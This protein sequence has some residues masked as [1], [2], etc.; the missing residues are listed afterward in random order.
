MKAHVLGFLL[1][2]FLVLAL[3]LIVFVV[4]LLLR[5][6]MNGFFLQVGL[7]FYTTGVFSPIFL[8]VEKNGFILAAILS[9]GLATL[10][11]GQQARDSDKMQK[12]LEQVL[13]GRLKASEDVQQL[14]QVKTKLNNYKNQSNQKHGKAKVS[15]IDGAIKILNDVINK[16]K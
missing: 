13:K 7:I 14:E 10:I 9:V 8:D 12:Q 3:A 4:W 6:K 16:N 1:N 5:K 11:Y 2:H 15:E